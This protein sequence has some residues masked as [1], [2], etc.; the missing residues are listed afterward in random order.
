M[1][2]YTV[3]Q[4]RKY[5][6]SQDSLGDVLY[7]LENIDKYIINDEVT[8]FEDEDDAHDYICDLEEYQ[9]EKFSIGDITY[10]ISDE[11]TDFIRDYGS[12]N[13]SQLVTRKNKIQDL[14]D[15]GLIEKI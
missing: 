7:N 15:N 1:K 11:V 9:G 6:Q 5:I 3:E 13:F 2:N 14:L 12:D 10:E 4:I 8:E